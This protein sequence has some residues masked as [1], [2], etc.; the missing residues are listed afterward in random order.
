[1]ALSLD[2]RSLLILHASVTG[3]AIDVAERIGRRGRREGWA[4]AVKSVAQ[5][6][7]A[8]LRPPL[9]G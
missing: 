1:M 4:V 9:L 7:Q 6:A 2:S 3:T 5:F 8:R